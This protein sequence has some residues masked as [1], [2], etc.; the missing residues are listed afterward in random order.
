MNAWNI[1]YIH[2]TTFTQLCYLNTF[3]LMNILNIPHVEQEV[4]SSDFPFLIFFFLIIFIGF[5]ISIVEVSLNVPTS[6]HTLQI[7]N[8]FKS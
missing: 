8:L 1:F 2:L 3:P 7:N 6:N 4:G 5:I